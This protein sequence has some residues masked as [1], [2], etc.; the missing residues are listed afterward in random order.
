MEFKKAVRKNIP[1]LIALAGTSG[2]GKTFS[3]ILIAAG[4]VGDKGKIAFIDT[5]MG[6]GAMYA[7]QELIVKA[8]PQGYD[9]VELTPPYTPAR[10]L[11]AMD[12]AIKAGYDCIIIDSITHEW[13]GE[14]G[15]T[16]I[17]ENNKLAG[18]PNWAMAKRE[19]K[20]FINKLLTMPVDVVCCLR[21]REKTKPEKQMVNGQ[22]KTVFV[23]Y[24]IQ[25]IQEK[26]FMFEMT[27]SLMLDDKHQ[28]PAIT[29][30]PESLRHIF[31]T[32]KRIT[33]EVGQ[34]IRQ[35][36]EGGAVIDLKARELKN[37]L[38]TAADEGVEKLQEAWGKLTAAE[39]KTAEKF[40][41]ELKKMAIAAEKQPEPE[42]IF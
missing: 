20:K 24:G 10:Y 18:L 33:K 38:A 6:R 4:L 36:S 5:E 37:K 34:K 31:P 9:I 26:N 27:F 12:A 2:S 28:I 29:K 17:A 14:G 3:A 41:D 30:C 19:H 16:D 13:E 39:Q 7:D 42:G 25:P 21:A 35:W 32:D 11:E 15:C 23:E 40:K 8:L 22:A 1:A